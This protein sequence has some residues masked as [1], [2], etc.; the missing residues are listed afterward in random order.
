MADY[1]LIVKNNDSEVQIDGTYKN[2]TLFTSGSQ[3]VTQT[4]SGTAV[5][6]NTNSPVVASKVLTTYFHCIS[7]SS[8]TSGTY[9]AA[10]IFYSEGSQTLPWVSYTYAHTATL[11]TYGLIVKNAAGTVVFSSEDEWLKI[12]GVDSSSLAYSVGGYTDVTVVD[13]VNNYFFLTDHSWEH[14]ATYN[15]SDWDHIV[16]SRGMK[17]IN[18]TTIRVGVFPYSVFSLGSSAGIGNG[19]WNSTF[20]LLEFGPPV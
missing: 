20:Q 5:T 4:G 7:G 6:I 18:S 14:T 9:V 3:A 10:I 8:S 17:R 19:S 11:P 1:G 15:G 13:A 2:Y 16:Y 12:I